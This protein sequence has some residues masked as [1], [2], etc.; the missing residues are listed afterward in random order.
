MMMKS[1][2]CLAGLALMALSACTG[3]GA[4]PSTPGAPATAPSTSASSSRPAS[5]TTAQV[6]THNSR[7]DC[8]AAVDGK[9]YDLTSW[10]NRHPG[11]PD[12]IIALC[13]TDATTAFNGQHGADERP[14]EQ[15]AEFQVGV[16]TD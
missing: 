13:G 6:A 12:K 4:P 8:W 14:H 5:F 15:L 10:I 16:L 7:T 3:A 1:S 2:L 11:G 9:V